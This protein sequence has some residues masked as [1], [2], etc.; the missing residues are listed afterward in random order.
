VWNRPQA[1]GYSIGDTVLWRRSDLV[2]GIKHLFRTRAHGN[3]V[4]QINPANHAI[5]IKEKFGR[6]RDVRSFRACPGMQHIIPANNLRLRIGKQ[7]ERVP[8]LVRL[9]FVD[10]RWIDA[11]ADDANATRLEIRQPLLE[12]PQ[13]GVTKSSPESAIENQRNRLRSR[14]SAEQFTKAEG[15][16]I[17]IQ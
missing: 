13:L 1:G 4:G 7:R 8:E 10:I 15:I 11:D 9:P 6:P 14:R 16:S 3:V 12:T 17:L 2:K 5:R